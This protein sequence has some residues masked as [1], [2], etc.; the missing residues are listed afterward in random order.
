MVEIH[1]SKELAVVDM[2]V[3]KLLIDRPGISSHK[4]FDSFP[5]DVNLEIVESH[6]SNCLNFTIWVTRA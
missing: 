5:D 1:N 4:V 6:K 3:T 2:V